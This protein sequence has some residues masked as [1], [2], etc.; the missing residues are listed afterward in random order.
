MSQDS[1]CGNFRVSAGDEDSNKDSIESA[2]P[3]S[4]PSPDSHFLQ[5]SEPQKH[6]PSTSRLN[7]SSLRTNSMSSHTVHSARMKRKASQ[8][9]APA[10]PPQ[11]DK[12]ARA[13]DLF[14][15]A[16]SPASLHTFKSDP[17]HKRGSRTA[18]GGQERGLR[19]K[20]I[21]GTR[22]RGQP[23]MRKRMGALLAQ[24]EAHK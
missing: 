7:A 8:Q 15:E 20:G 4:S 5:P 23:D 17:L 16:Y 11:D 1:E 22:G 6:F 10:A 18:Q 3:R 12:A 13:R 19:N 21:G 24:I 2:S 9:A 14:R